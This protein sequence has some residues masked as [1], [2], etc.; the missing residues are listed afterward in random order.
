[1]SPTLFSPFKLRNLT[2]A[3]RII[4]SP[5]CQYSAIDGRATDW[6]VVH[7]GQ[8]LQSRAGMFMIDATA[9]SAIN[10]ITPGYIGLYENTCEHAL[11]ERLA[12]ARAN[13]PA[14]PVGMQLAHAGRKGSSHV[15]W[16]GGQ[17]IPLAEGGWTPVAPSPVAQVASEPP[18]QALAAIDLEQI[19]VDFVAAT[20]RAAESAHRR[21]RRILRQP[22]ALSAR[23]VSCDARCLA[24]RKADGGTDFVYRLDR[25]R[26]DDR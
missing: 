14:M 26:M 16:E 11:H 12:I 22:R 24:A 13:A 20:H 18:S 3:N 15:P 23:R 25:R 19:K 6:H 17:L 5:M 2:L 9:V 4:V 7:W 21:V 10:P 1:M 8:L